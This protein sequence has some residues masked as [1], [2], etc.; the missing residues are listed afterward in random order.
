M[1]IV[2]IGR[3]LVVRL[4][5]VRLGLGLICPIGWCRI[6]FTGPQRHACPDACPCG[7]QRYEFDP[8]SRREPER[9]GSQWRAGGR[10]GFSL[11]LGVGLSLRLII[12]R[13]FDG[14]GRLIARGV[15]IVC[16]VVF[17]LLTPSEA[18][19]PPLETSHLQPGMVAA[20]NC[21][22]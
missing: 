22:T 18:C 1:A 12:I 7:R 20:A 8:S 13:R 21:R 5:T 14:I 16:G 15:C 19:S 11:G 6:E 3:L 9:H 2:S 10:G 17:L 4:N